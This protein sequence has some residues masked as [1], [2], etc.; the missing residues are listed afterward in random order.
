[1]PIPPDRAVPYPASPPARVLALPLAFGRSLLAPFET[2][3]TAA[4]GIALLALAAGIAVYALIPEQ[5]SRTAAFVAEQV[6]GFGIADS[7]PLRMA[8]MAFCAMLALASVVRR[9]LGWPRIAIPPRLLPWTACLA[10]LAVLAIQFNLLDSQPQPSLEPEM[11]WVTWVWLTLA[12]GLAIFILGPRL[13]TPAIL[14]TA[15]AGVLLMLLPAASPL[16][17]RTTPATLPWIDAHLT[18]MFAGGEMLA[19]SYRFLADVPLSYGLFV[20]LAV[21]AAVRAGIAPDLGDLVRSLQ[22]SQAVTLALFLLAAWQATRGAALRARALLLLMMVLVALPFLSTG[23]LAVQFPNQSGLRFLLF[24]IAALV[25][26]GLRSPP[27][28]RIS[29]IAGAVA[30][31]AL[32]HNLETGVATTMGLGLAWLIRVRTTGWR[33]WTA[34]LAAVIA[35]AALV[36]LATLLAFRLAVGIWPDLAL[37]SGTTYA[38]LFAGGFGGLRPSFRLIVLV[39]FGHAA[40]AVARGMAALLRT[41]DTRVDPFSAGLGGI[42]IAWAP[43]YA[44]RPHDWNLWV[45]LLLYVLLLAPLVARH[46]RHTGLMTIVIVLVALPIPL[47]IGLMN[48]SYQKLISDETVEPGC[49]AGLSLP[50][51]I[52]AEQRERTA[53]LRRAAA[54]GDILWITAYTYATLRDSRLKPFM[55]PLNI[56]LAIRTERELTTIAGQIAAARP[57]ALLL[58][59]G[60]PGVLR[61]SVPAPE[62]ALHERVARQAGFER[63]ALV[64]LRR[65]DAW[66]PTGTCTETS[67]PV[68]ALR[69][70]LTGG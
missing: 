34:A 3:D 46:W 70:R 67:A 6:Q 4:L 58:D 49:L 13:P 28:P 59:G 26:L 53:E 52:C 25:L 54:P 51:P 16:M 36:A 62:R 50:A 47:A 69:T 42:I 38:E 9:V 21:T 15:A 63:C 20:Q 19:A 22:I 24:P 27:L 35:A 64:P 60:G 2:I 23:S 57:R 43:Y 12:T 33:Q 41:N 68:Q 18:A 1:M 7:A 10:A 14:A 48:Q 44:N 61:D 29:A 8:L 45:T 31:L 66:L 65:W 37:Q 17:L 55:P 40:Y 11:R 30:M 56:F 39:V 5:P 32:L